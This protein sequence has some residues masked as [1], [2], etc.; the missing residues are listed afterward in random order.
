[1]PPLPGDLRFPFSIIF[2]AWHRIFLVSQSEST[3]FRFSLNGINYSHPI[4]PVDVTSSLQN[5]E[6]IISFNLE[7][8]TTTVYAM[9]CIKNIE[10][11]DE[12]VKHVLSFHKLDSIP[13]NPEEVSFLCPI[14]GE[15]IQN[16]GRGVHCSH[17]QTFDIRSFLRRALETNNWMCPI[18]EQSLPFLH[19]RYEPSFLRSVNL[20]DEDDDDTYSRQVCGSELYF[21]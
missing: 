11:I 17:R 20:N 19:L 12:M 18:C 5:G 8:N 21:F 2:E 14:S 10:N 13:P 4:F 16:P 9:L 7:G 3:K 15:F 6:N 1:M